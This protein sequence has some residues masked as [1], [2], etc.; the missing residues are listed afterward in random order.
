MLPLVQ[1]FLSS[2]LCGFREGYSTQHALLR[3]IETCN[4]SI[5]SGGIAGVVL[6]D[7]LKAFDC[8]DHELLIAKLN[9]YG[10]NRSASLFV[11]SYLDSRKQMVRLNG[12]FNMWT[13]TSLGVPQGSV[14]GPLLI[15]IYLNDLSLFPEETEV[16]NYEDDTSI[17][18]CRECCRKIRE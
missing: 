18:T 8:L 13:K 4:K 7:L 1:S 9:A 3:L 6:K 15:N 5:D 2:L 14:L 12:S 10:F 11:R 17:Y 16:C